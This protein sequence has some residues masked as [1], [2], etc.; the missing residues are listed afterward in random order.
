MAVSKAY[1]IWRRSYFSYFSKASRILEN[2]FL[3]MLLLELMGI[4][5]TV[6]ILQQSSKIIL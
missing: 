2:N 1:K 6:S 3:I 4:C 5:V